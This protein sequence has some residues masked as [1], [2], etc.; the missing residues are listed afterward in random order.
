MRRGLRGTL[1]RDYDAKELGLNPVAR[2][3]PPDRRVGL[4]R[5]D[6]A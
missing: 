1:E 5:A 3:D 6:S 2:A 4:L